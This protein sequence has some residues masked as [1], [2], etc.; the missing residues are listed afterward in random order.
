MT[1]KKILYKIGEKHR[2]P[3]L[4]FEI[5]YFKSSIITGKKQYTSLFIKTDLPCIKGNCRQSSLYPFME[6]VKILLLYNALRV[7]GFYTD[8][9]SSTFRPS[10]NDW[11][12]TC[13][14][15]T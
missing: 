6:F 2:Y 10:N 7:F 12:S 5:S 15:E 9:L 11:C 1:R 13:E 14:P 3:F 4:S 8:F